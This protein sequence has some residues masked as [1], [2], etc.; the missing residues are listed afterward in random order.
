[1]ATPGA[2]DFLVDRSDPGNATRLFLDSA[3]SWLRTTEARGPAMESVSRAMVDGRVS[4]AEGH[5]LFL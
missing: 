5:V 2:L 4:P 1:M 3:P